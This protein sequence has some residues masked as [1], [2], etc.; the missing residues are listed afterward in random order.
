VVAMASQRTR[1]AR[2]AGVAANIDP[3]LTIIQYTSRR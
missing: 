1:Q 3:G 2:A